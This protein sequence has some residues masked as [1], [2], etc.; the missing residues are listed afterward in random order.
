MGNWG[1]HPQITLVQLGTGTP[2]RAA[3]RRGARDHPDRRA[4][5][6][7]PRAR[8]APAERGEVRPA[9][10][11]RSG[12]SRSAG[13]SAEE[14]AR[15]HRDE[16]EGEDEGSDHREGDRHRHGPEQL[17]LD[18]RNVR[19][20]TYTV[21]MISTAKVSGRATSTARVLHLSRHPRAARAA[22][23]Q[24]AH[25]VLGHDHRAVHDDPE[26]DRPQGEQVG[27]DPAEVHEDEREQQ[28]EGNR[29]GHD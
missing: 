22:L 2:C 6:R 25:D 28:R 17:A 29:E 3:R 19:I 13:R 9:E 24:P 14:K 15:E 18:P 21:M 1:P 10:Q 27:R 16:G 26:V 7:P 5:H 8:E 20:G 23:G 4:Q 11:R 12:L